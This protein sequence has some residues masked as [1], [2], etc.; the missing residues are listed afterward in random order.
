[1]KYMSY[2]VSNQMDLYYHG[3][4]EI[5]TSHCRPRHIKQRAARLYAYRSMDDSVAHRQ[6]K[7]AWTE[8]T[9]QFDEEPPDIP[10][11]IQNAENFMKKAKDDE[12]SDQCGDGACEFKRR[13]YLLEKR[14]CVL[15]KEYAR[16]NNNS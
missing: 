1:M 11:L 14:V 6:H 4:I 10:A 13:I 8:Y 3:N 9:H 12:C 7:A 2:N 5:Y 15:K 16:Q